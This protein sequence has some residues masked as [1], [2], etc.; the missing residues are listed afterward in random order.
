MIARFR[1]ALLMVATVALSAIGCS[2]DDDDLAALRTQVAGFQTQLA[3]PTP[4]PTPTRAP[5]AT[6]TPDAR[7]FCAA[8]GDFRDK[9]Q[10][11]VD[12]FNE[13]NTERSRFENFTKADNEELA[14]LLQTARSVFVPLPPKD[15]EGRF[16]RMNTLVLALKAEDDRLVSSIK[17]IDS[18]AFGQAREASNALSEELEQLHISLCP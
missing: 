4:T 3:E 15:A 12:R 1:P 8:V 11:V 13:L 18:M 14:N 5:S 6:P 10:T 16:E 7:G 9:R 17:R 2:G